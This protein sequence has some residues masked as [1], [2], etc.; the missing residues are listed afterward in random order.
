ME[1]ATTIVM[2]DTD[3]IPT[4]IMDTEDT[5]T[6]PTTIMGMEDTDTIPTTIMGMEDIM[7]GDISVAT[8]EMKHISPAQF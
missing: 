1:T 6:I 8:Q 4:T 3:T 7:V 2:E 5:D